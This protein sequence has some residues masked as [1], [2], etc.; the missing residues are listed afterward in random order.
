[1]KPIL[2]SIGSFDIYGYGLMIALG[3]IAGIVLA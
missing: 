2:F 3:I 1:M